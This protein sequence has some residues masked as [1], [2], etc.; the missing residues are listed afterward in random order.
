MDTYECSEAVVWYIKGRRVGRGV[1][2]GY[3]LCVDVPVQ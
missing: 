2:L 1:G 3:I